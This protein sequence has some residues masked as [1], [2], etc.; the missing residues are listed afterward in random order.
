MKKV[1]KTIKKL[2]AGILAAACV[3]SMSVP[4]MADD[5]QVFVNFICNGSNSGRY[6]PA[7]SNVT[8]PAVPLVGGHT[9]CG[10]DKSLRNVTTNTTFTA[11]YLPDSVGEEAIK[12]KKASLPTPAITATTVADPNAAAPAPAVQAAPAAASNTAVQAAPAAA[13]NTAAL[14]SLAQAQQAAAQVA[15]QKAATDAA[16]PAEAPAAAQPAA[17]TPAVQPATVQAAVQAQP[18]EEAKAQAAPAAPAPAVVTG[19]PGWAVSLHGVDA[20]G[21]AEVYKY[22]KTVKNADDATI[23]GNWD[24]LL[25]HYSGHGTQGW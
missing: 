25:N 11:I 20:N 1:K 17:Q 2:I 23:Q 10:F 4:A 19:L 21:C 13:S 7:G 18:A 12:A 22:W 16:K 9:F 3:L 6:V 24:A 8:A 15:A 5:P 14:A